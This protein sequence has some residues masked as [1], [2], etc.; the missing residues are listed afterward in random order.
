[1]CY[2]FARSF[3]KKPSCRRRHFVAVLGD[4]EKSFVLNLW[5]KH[6]HILSAVKHEHGGHHTHCHGNS[7][8]QNGH[9]RCY[10]EECGHGNQ[11]GVVAATHNECHSLHES[12]G[13][14][15]I[16]KMKVDNVCSTLNFDM[17]IFVLF[18]DHLLY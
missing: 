3:E 2:S 17:R 15:I 9:H 18:K 7:N 12:L 5:L 13:E 16:Q 11:D 14:S 10:K 6:Q 4:H 8:H 1:M